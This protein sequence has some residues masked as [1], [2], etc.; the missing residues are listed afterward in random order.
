MQKL[1]QAGSIEKYP[2]ANI[3]FVEKRREIRYEVDGTYLDRNCFLIKMLTEPAI[4]YF[5]A[6]PVCEYYSDC[7]KAMVRSA[8]VIKPDG[9]VI[10]VPEEEIVDGINPMYSQMNV[11]DSTMRLITINFKDIQVGDAVDYV[12]EERCDRPRFPGFDLKEGKY[13]QE[14]EPVIHMQIEIDGPEKKPLN[15]LLKCSENLDIKFSSTN[16]NGRTRYVWEA[17][18]IPPFVSEPGW[19]TREHFAARLI[20]STMNSWLEMS[21]SGYRSNRPSIDQNDSLRTVVAQI[22]RGLLTDEEKITHIQKFLRKNIKYMS[23]TTLSQTAGKPATRTIA[24]GFGVCRDVAVLMCS[25]LETAGIESYPAATG[26]GRVIDDEV[27]HD[28][29]Q[30]MIVAV[31]DRKVGYR[32]YDP[33]FFLFSGN[34]LPGYASG[35]A[36]LVYTPKGEDLTRIP[37]IPA[38]E[39]MGTIKAESRIDDDGR[40]TS[41]VSITGLGFYD[42]DL[43]RWRKGVDA[44]KF[45]TRWNE[46]ANQLC[47]G[48]KLTDLSTSDPEDLDTPFCIRFSYEVPGYATAT[49][50]SLVVKA[51]LSADCFERVLVDIIAKTRLPERRHPF[52]ITTTAGADQNETLLLPSG[53]TVKSMPEDIALTTS[54]LDLKVQYKAGIS[55]EGNR[56][57]IEFSKRFTVDSRQ[58]DPESYLELR[59]IKEANASSGKGEIVLVKDK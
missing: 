39:N 21:R 29:F 53:W 1:S 44:E 27:P 51:S 18:D 3:I 52:I 24:D 33:S 22:T 11:N 47:Q 40:L 31:P 25:M 56:P 45:N 28:I 42:E 49:G 4:G 10:D 34:P 48:A 16:T 35:A 17:S 7:S 32:L 26:Y 43:R 38:R 50:D 46:I 8:R 37:Q 14:D 13:I 59:K 54:N 41:T 12:I 30:H 58:F 6:L 2:R 19:N 20:A 9:T 5:G 15:H 55:S 57:Q 23:A 36:L